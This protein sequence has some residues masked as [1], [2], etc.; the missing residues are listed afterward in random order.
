MKELKDK[1]IT[2]KNF[3]DFLKENKED[4]KLSKLKELI[5]QN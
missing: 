1:M 2:A 5:N 3:I 4:K